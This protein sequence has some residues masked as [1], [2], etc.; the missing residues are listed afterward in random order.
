MG[1][2]IKVTVAAFFLFAPLV[3]PACGG[4]D[5]TP[6]VVR[7]GVDKGTVT[8]GDPIEYTVTVR[9]DPNYTLLSSI[10]APSEDVFKVKKIDDVRRQEGTVLIEGKKFTLTAY[11]LGDFVLDPVKIDYRDEKG[12]TQSL[13]TSPIYIKVASVAEGTEKKDIRDVKTV[14]SIPRSNFL[15]YLCVVAA[16]LALICWLL[17]LWILRRQKGAV[18]IPEPKLD[19]EQEAL[20]R[21]DALI[22]SELLRKGH[23]KLYFLQFSDIL[24]RYFERRLSISAPEATTEEILAQIKSKELPSEIRLKIKEVLEAADLAKFA[25]WKPAPAEIL[26]INQQAKRLIEECRPKTDSSSGSENPH[27]L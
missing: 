20:R 4:D 25:K 19:P 24:K 11:R 12:D 6:V 9:R 26:S 21:L 3:P 1:F 18:L 2:S 13:T 10:E 23:T 27:E 14:V 8:I 15:I 17:R 16:M 5:P 7:A 22:E